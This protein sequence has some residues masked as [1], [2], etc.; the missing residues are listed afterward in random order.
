[1]QRALTTL[2]TLLFFC[3]AN[4]EETLLELINSGRIRIEI[5][6]NG[7]DSAVLKMHNLTAENLTASIASGTQL[8]SNNGE[9]QIVIRTFR[10]ELAASSESEAILPTAAFSSKNSATQ[11]PLKLSAENDPKLGALLALFDKYN[12][13]PRP[14]AQIAVFIMLEDMNFAEWQKWMEPKWAQENPR[15]PHPNPTEISQLIDAIGLVKLAEP[16]RQ[17]KILADEMLKRLALKNSFARGKAMALYGL[18][19]D[20]AISG[21]PSQPPNLNQLLHLSPGDNCPIC[22]QRAKMQPDLP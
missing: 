19:V 13:L 18:S 4:A 5:S 14:T 16:Q 20:D 12:D 21:E 11:R 2:L 9:K 15:K 8:I 17:P 6:G 7:H 10:T 22:R 3:A 1:M